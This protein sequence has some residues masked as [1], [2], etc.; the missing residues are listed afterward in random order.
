VADDQGDAGSENRPP[1]FS[2]GDVRLVCPDLGRNRDGDVLPK[3]AEV[4][5]PRAEDD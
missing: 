2:R 5:V 3:A 4:R 1:D